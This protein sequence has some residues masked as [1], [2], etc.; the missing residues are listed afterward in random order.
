MDPYIK[1]NSKL[2]KEL[3]KKWIHKENMVKYL[4]ALSRG[5][6]SHTVKA[7]KEVIKEKK[8]IDLTI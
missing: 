3:G 8:T 5:K 7:K 4:S 1:I 2:I 6:N